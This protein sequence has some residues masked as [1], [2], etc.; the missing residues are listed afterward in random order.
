MAHFLCVAPGM[1][2]RDGVLEYCCSCCCPREETQLALLVASPPSPCTYCNCP[3]PPSA[4]NLTLWGSAGQN[5]QWDQGHSVIS[6][7][8]LPTFNLPR[9][10]Y[11][12]FQIENIIFNYKNPNRWNINSMERKEFWTLHF[13]PSAGQN[14]EVVQNRFLLFWSKFASAFFGKYEWSRPVKTYAQHL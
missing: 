8:L 10:S 7:R 9:T 5:S 13:N 14:P 4:T 6:R 12:E 1:S 3:T 11:G 2:R